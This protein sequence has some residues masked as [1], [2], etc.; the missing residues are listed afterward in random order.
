MLVITCFPDV[1]G[2]SSVA[3]PTGSAIDADR[4]LQ[5]ELLIGT[6]LTLAGGYGSRCQRRD[7]LSPGNRERSSE[8]T[9]QVIYLLTLAERFG[10][11]KVMEMKLHR[12]R[13]VRSHYSLLKQ[14]G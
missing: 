2:S 6:V 8:E 13:D 10:A 1:W 9:S 3:R 11:A 5:Q 7:T 4:V 14:Y 12:L